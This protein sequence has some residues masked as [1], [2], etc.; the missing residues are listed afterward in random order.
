[1][2]H[3]TSNS[4]EDRNEVPGPPSFERPVF[5]DR[6]NRICLLRTRIERAI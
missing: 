2:I 3:K 5:G 4:V 6:K 1:M